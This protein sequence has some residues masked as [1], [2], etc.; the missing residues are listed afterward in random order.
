[1]IGDQFWRLGRQK[2][3]GRANIFFK[4]TVTPPH[5]LVD[6]SILVTIPLE[7]QHQTGSFRRPT[8]PPPRGVMTG[9]GNHERFHLI[10]RRISRQLFKSLNSNVGIR[11]YP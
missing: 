11:Q 4:D 10:P 7:P 5:P 3:C 8:P 6:P 1:M 9:E 2:H